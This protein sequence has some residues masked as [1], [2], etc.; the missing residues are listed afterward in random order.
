MTITATEFK[1][2]LGKYLSL[3]GVITL[4]VTVTD[5][6]GRTFTDTRSLSILDYSFPSIR[7]FAADRCNEAGTEAQ[8]DSSHVRYSFRGA[9][10]SLDN[11]NATEY[12][13]YYKLSTASTWTLTESSTTAGQYDI[14]VQS[15]AVKGDFPIT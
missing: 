5:S 12:Y 10:S 2:N 8:R 1:L 11:A 15:Y 7:L 3:A 4:T 6:R 9:I 13:I 14:T